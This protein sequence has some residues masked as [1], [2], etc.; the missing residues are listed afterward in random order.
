MYLNFA[1]PPLSMKIPRFGV[2]LPK[3][4]AQVHKP[5]CNQVPYIALTLPHT[6]DA[7]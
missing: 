3:H 4:V 5:L 2:Q 6:V 1:I 7:K